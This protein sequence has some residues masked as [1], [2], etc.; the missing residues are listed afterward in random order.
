MYFAFLYLLFFAVD[1][2]FVTH[3]EALGLMPVHFLVAGMGLFFSGCLLKCSFPFEDG[4]QSRL[5]RRVFLIYILIIS[6][7]NLANGCLRSFS[8]VSRISLDKWFAVD[9]WINGAILTFS[10]IL[11]FLFFSAMPLRHSL[12]RWMLYSV[13]AGILRYGVGHVWRPLPVLL[14]RYMGV[15]DFIMLFGWLMVIDTLL[16][17]EYGFVSSDDGHLVVR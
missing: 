2:L 3:F 9:F 5:F 4:K 14:F 8:S 13:G 7:F 12:S 11:F 16:R 15:L 10:L 6:L 1:I 17:R